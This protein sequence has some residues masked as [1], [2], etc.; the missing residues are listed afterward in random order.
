MGAEI[1]P[2]FLWEK[3]GQETQKVYLFVM[4]QASLYTYASKPLLSIQ[5]S[6]S[7][8]VAISSTATLAL[9]SDR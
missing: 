4:V 6:L 2:Y 9:R 5:A 1:A 8:P 3:I 7:I